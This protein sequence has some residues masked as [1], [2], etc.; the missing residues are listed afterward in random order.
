MR[1]LFLALDRPDIQFVAKEISRAMANPT[2]N[3][4]ETL[5]GV[6]RYLVGHQ[7][8]IW[9]Y[10]RQEWPGK[11]W[12]MTDSN[13]AACPVTRK[14]TSSTYLAFGSHPIYTASS[15]QTILS[16]SSGEAELFAAVRCACRTFV[17]LRNLLRDFGIEVPADLVTDSTACKG[18]ASR[19]GAGKVRHI[20]C[21][22]LWLQHAIARRQLGIRKRAGKDLPPDIGTK[23]SITSES[24]WRLLGSFGVVQARGRAREALEAAG[25]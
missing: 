17:G 8:V 14:S 16:L 7:R 2:V 15:T 11:I 9:R 25:A 24:M 12:G 6:A 4:D 19:R 10:P 23:A 13:W 20:H 22:A 1:C 3:A 5:R 21:P 18:L